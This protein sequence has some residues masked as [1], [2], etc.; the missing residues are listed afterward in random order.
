MRRSVGVRRLFQRLK[1]FAAFLHRTVI[2]I[3]S[4]S[5]LE[6]DKKFVN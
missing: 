1:K 6:Y 2:E 5:R 4:Q 3:D